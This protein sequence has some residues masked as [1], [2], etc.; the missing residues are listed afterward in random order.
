M[1]DKIVVSPDYLIQLAIEKGIDIAAL[2]K[3]MQLKRD[4]DADQAKKAYN[5]AYS[6]FQEKKPDIPKSQKVMMRNKQTNQMEHKYSFAPLALIQE[7]VDPILSL[8]GL[9]YTWKQKEDEKFI[10]ITFVL[11]HVDGHSEE[12]YLSAPMDESGGKNKIQAIGSTVSYLK[13]YTMMNGLGISADE[14]NDGLT[15]SLTKEEIQQA[16]KD[17]LVELAMVK[18]D[19]MDKSTKDGID[20]IIANNQHGRYKK[21]IEALMKL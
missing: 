15:S 16:A 3:L 14:D 11:K 9:S 19:K 17:K 10:G 12:N 20:F 1:S 6:K 8:F 2:E 13:R 4:Y 5:D 7:K 21:A 18:A